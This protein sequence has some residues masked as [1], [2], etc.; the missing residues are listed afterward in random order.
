MANSSKCVSFER[1]DCDMKLFVLN[2]IFLL[3]IAS[4]LIGC[5]GGEIYPII[6]S[7][8]FGNNYQYVD[9]AS[10]TQM[11]GTVVKFRDGDGDVGLAEGDTLAP[12]NSIIGPNKK[13]V[14][15]FYYNLYIEYLRKENGVYKNVINDVTGDTLREN[16]R[17]MPLTPEGKF[18][19]IRG[20][21]EVQF[22]PAV[23]LN[24]GDTVKLKY[25]LIDRA[26]HLSNTAESTDIVIKR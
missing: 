26:L 12:Y 2:C 21:I 16:M 1:I 8:E 4:L 9:Q 5:K 10:S 13:N 14:N 11:I 19:A 22:E 18:K 17:V 15:L 20:T 23:Y 6:P 3:G 7:I 25:L 24:A